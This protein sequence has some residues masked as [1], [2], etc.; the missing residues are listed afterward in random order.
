M[1]AGLGG[2]R[3]CVDGDVPAVA[4][5][6]EEEEEKEGPEAGVMEV[7]EE[8]EEG[9]GGGSWSGENTISL[10]FFRRLSGLSELNSGDHGTMVGFTAAFVG[11]M[12]GCCCCCGDCW[13]FGFFG[14]PA[15]VVVVGV[16][17]MEGC[18]E[19]EVECALCRCSL[20]W[21]WPWTRARLGGSG[22][23]EVVGLST[24]A[25]AAAAAS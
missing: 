1:S 11:I 4:G 15:A 5:R 13:V 12:E 7:G 17:G 19:D 6:D 22:V 16:V 23:A 18:S 24:A 3:L 8:E 10:I 2:I 25:A 21:V 9:E 14:V 20:A